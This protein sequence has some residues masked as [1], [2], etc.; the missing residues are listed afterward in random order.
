MMYEI[1][2]MKKEEVLWDLSWKVHEARLEDVERVK[3]ERKP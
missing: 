2:R 1:N 3:C